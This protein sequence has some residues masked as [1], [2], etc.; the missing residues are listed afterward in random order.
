M[1]VAPSTA[2]WLRSAGLTVVSSGAAAWGDMAVASNIICCLSAS[3]DA[4][5][6]V[7][8]QRAFFG[9]PRVVETL[10]VPGA[11]LGLLG[12]ATTIRA[13][14]EGYRDGTVVFV[15]A[16]VE[17]EDGMSSLTVIRRLA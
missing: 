2:D 17:R 11:Q 1:T 10:L 6:E 9:S 16:V 13:D 5:M 7:D 4:Q 15:I 14:A 12:R 8:R 3:A